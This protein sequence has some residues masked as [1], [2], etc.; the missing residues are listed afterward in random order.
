MN[1]LH[2]FLIIACTLLLSAGSAVAFP[3]A[4]GDQIVFNNGVGT[5]NA[6]QFDV[7][8]AGSSTTLFST[9]CLEKNE[10][11]SHGTPFVVAG[12]SDSTMSSKYG[13]DP[14]DDKTK[15][16]YW[17]FATGDLDKLVNTYSYNT[18]S[19]AN[20]LQRAIWYFEDEI[21]SFSDTVAGALI[22]AASDALQGIGFTEGQVSVINLKYLNGNDAQ[23][24]LIAAPVPEPS[25][26]LLLGSGLAGAVLLH[27]R[28]KK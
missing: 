16:L 24:Q 2:T 21:T 18:D 6:G 27:R 9:F 5:V 15:W 25:T 22:S 19:G 1:R 23:D 17:H 8:K 13:A 10:Y 26:L 3:I 11:L 7:S 14:L 12:I 28:R 20:G 4:T